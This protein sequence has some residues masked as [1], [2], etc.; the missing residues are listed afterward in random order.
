M[1]ERPR[2][3]RQR[4]FKGGSISHASG[5]AMD[6]IIRNLS[7]TGACLEVSSPFGIP[8]NFKLIIRP[9]ILTRSCE[10]VL[11]HSTADR[12]ALQ[13]AGKQQPLSPVSVMSRLHPRPWQEWLILAVGDP[14]REHAITRADL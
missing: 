7:D 1:A 5:A 8:D 3:Q 9:E 11:A 10:V 13:V 6:C 4:T 14:V 12:R 2:S